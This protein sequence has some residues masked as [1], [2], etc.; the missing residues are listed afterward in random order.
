MQ[1]KP[2]KL[3]KDP[4]EVTSQ[5][6]DELLTPEEAALLLGRSTATLQ[7][8]RIDGKGPPYLEITS[9]G[10]TVVRH[11]SDASGSRRRGRKVIR[12]VR[13]WLFRPCA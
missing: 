10:I 7:D 8:W 2:M 9:K 3:V 12:Y 13:S 5:V 6:L 4:Y 1:T 11:T